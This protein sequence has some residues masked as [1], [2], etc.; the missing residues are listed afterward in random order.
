MTYEKPEVR[1]L[2]DIAKHT[3]I[4]PGPD[5]CWPGQSCYDTTDALVD[6]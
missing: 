3:Y 4:V 6:G 2:G 5:I 1:D